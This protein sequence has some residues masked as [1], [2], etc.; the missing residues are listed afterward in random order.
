M[1]EGP[2][3]RKIA[4][5]L[6]KR[7]GGKNLLSYE[8][9]GGRYETHGEPDGFKDLSRSLPIQIAG[10]GCHGKFIFIILSGGS[11][12]W[13]TLGMTGSW[14]RKREPHSKIKF[15]L[16]DG[17]I[18][19]TDPRNFGTIRFVSDG[20]MLIDKISSLGP[21]MLGEDVSNERFLE[22]IRS[23]KKKTCIRFF[24]SVSC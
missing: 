3:V 7:V 6:A 1:P 18:F 9:L 15:T 2:E 24:K 19:F 13:C 23:C 20:K 12:I 4:E 8:I 17:E 16:S 14:T 22:R 10:A 21:D 5:S 11:S